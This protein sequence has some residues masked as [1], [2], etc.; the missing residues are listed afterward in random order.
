[1]TYI[2]ELE[3]TDGARPLT[4]VLSSL[5]DEVAAHLMVT[6]KGHSREL[7]MVLT[8]LDEAKMWA[9]QH[10]LKVGSHVLMD[11]RR[12]KVTEDA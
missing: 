10:G 4:D 3:E 9:T 1:M 11:K 8:K 12:L 7:A 2:S 6:Y 5:T